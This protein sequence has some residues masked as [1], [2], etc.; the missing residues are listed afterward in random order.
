[1]NRRNYQSPGNP[2]IPS[3]ARWSG[4]PV[5]ALM[6]STALII[7]GPAQAQETEAVK[8]QV[9]NVPVAVSEGVFPCRPGPWGNLEYFYIN[10]EAPEDFVNESPIP[11]EITVWRFVGMSSAETIQFLSE[12]GIPSGLWVEISRNSFW[13]TSETETRVLPNDTVIASLPPLVRQKIYSVARPWRENGIFFKPIIMEYESANQWF[14]GLDIPPP[15]LDLISRTIFPLGEGQAFS[16]IPFI[17]SQL[18]DESQRRQFLRALTRTRSIVLRMRMD[19]SL[20]LT[21]IAHYWSSGSRHIDTLPLLKAMAR[22]R[23]VDTLDVTHFLPP[24]PRKHIYSFPSPSTGFSGTFPDGYWTAFNFF[25]F[26]PDDEIETDTESIENR[27]RSGYSLIVEPGKFGDLIVL[28]DPNDGAP[29]HACVYVADDIV[30]TKNGPS[31]FRPWTMSK[32]NSVVTTW[33]HRGQPLV[34]FWRGK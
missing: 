15:A 21:S 16:D 9:D 18:E 24:L 1:M 19:E 4:A 10:T 17:L 2:E 8:I 27:L 13:Y 32:L 31:V 29:M 14:A 28:R 30:Y 25:E 22:T 26:W 33:S 34:E 3:T 11:S 20:D 6:L 23:G 7:T 12:V 5:V